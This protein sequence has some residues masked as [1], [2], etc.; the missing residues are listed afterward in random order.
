MGLK[1][2]EHRLD[3]ADLIQTQS[4]LRL[5]YVVTHIC[6]ATELNHRVRKTENQNEG[7]VQLLDLCGQTRTQNPSMR[8]K[9][10]LV[11]ERV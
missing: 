8:N 3:L 2:I 9:R 11:I 5:M 6:A 10:L 1:A 4:S 7:F